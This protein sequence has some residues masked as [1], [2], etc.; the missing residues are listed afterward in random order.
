MGRRR[1]LR[2]LKGTDLRR[3]VL[4]LDRAGRRPVQGHRARILR[5][6]LGRLLGVRAGIDDDEDR[7]V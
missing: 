5:Q 6:T 7:D 2:L 3:M 1:L 4:G